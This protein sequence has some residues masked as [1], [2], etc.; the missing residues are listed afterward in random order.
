ML[1]ETNN[2]TLSFVETGK[3]KITLVFLHYFGGS[4][5]TW[6]K[7]IKELSNDYRCIAIDLPGFGDS[8][9]T[10]ATLSVKENAKI[11]ADLIRVLHKKKSY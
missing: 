7:V 9:I 5:K 2:V 8:E 6:A 11:V 1:P 4:Y 3:G 10:S